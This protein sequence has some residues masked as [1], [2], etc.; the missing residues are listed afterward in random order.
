MT[1]RCS[2]NTWRDTI[3]FMA[4]L[5]RC[6]GGISNSPTGSF[7]PPSWHICGIWRS[8]MTRVRLSY[9]VF[10]LIYGQSKAGKT[11]F[12]ETLLKMMIGQKLK[13]SAPDFTRS[14][15]ET[16]K[17]TVHGAPIIVDDLT[18]TRF[19]QHAIETIKKRRFWCGR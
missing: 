2:W 3:S 14:S 7:A 5:P 16:L 12:L 10:G 18:N 9:P 8:D 17:C 6:S 1:S 4:M 19:N 13:L 11:S 15:I